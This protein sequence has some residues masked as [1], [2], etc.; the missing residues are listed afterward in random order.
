MTIKELIQKLESYENKNDQ[1]CAIL[2]NEDDVR[3][4]NCDDN[5]IDELDDNFKGEKLTSKQI[6]SVLSLLDS[7]HDAEYG[8]N[9]D[10]IDN[11]LEAIIDN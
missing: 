5:G 1:I 3:S 8:V 2:W 7:C 9:W 10:S 4:R 6:G 11:H